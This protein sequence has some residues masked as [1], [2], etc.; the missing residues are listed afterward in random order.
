VV[1]GAGAKV[2]GNIQISDRVRIGAGSIVLRDVPPDS[3]V[4][5]IPGRIISQ[6]QKKRISPLEHGKLPDVEAGIIRSLLS[7]IE[8][9]EQQVK[10]LKNHQQ[11]DV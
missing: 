3:T 6:K 5:G 2:L 11:D 8:Q 7:R 9:L 1:V 4:V 10:T